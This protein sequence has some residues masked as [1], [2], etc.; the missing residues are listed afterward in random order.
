MTPSANRSVHVFRL[1][2]RVPIL[3][4]LAAL[5]GAAQAVTPVATVTV[6]DA[7]VA[8]GYD[9]DGVVQPVRQSTLAAQVP[10][11]VTA[12]HVKAG[13]AVKAGQLLATLDDRETQVGVQGSQARVA[14][15]EAE[16]TQ[17]R[18]DLERQRSLQ[19]KGFVSSAAL[20]GAEARFKS[21]LAARDQ[22]RAGAGQSA[23]SQG[24]TRVTAPYAGW[25]LQTQ[26]EPGDLA[27]PGRPLLTVYA[28]QPLRAVVQV[29][30]SRAQ[31]TRGGDRIEIQLPDGQ[32]VAPVQR[33]AL[34]VAD[35]VSQTVEWR[36]ELPAAA[37]QAVVPGQQVR[38]R[39]AAGPVQRS[40]VPAAALLRRGELTAVY[41]LQDKAFV[42][43]AVRVGAD[44]GAAGL[45][46]LAGLKA[47]DRVAVDAVRAG[48]RDAV[49]Q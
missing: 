6:Q 27:L 13:D 41:V 7:A 20:D 16:L 9:W 47:G 46:V 44:H 40:L 38:V 25:V 32:W 42:L 2:W 12:L 11:R 28:P 8:S 19:A 35:A 22:A 33:Q 39:F 17:A 43:R 24:F 3:V 4:A 23:L 45:E 21:A 14:Q 48:L 36:L 31:L 34:P 37:A 10:G 15:A 49:A 18:L 1:G 5:A 26:A 30:A 29:P